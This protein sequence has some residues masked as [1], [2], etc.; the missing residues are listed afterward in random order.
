[1]AIY[2]EA[3]APPDQQAFAPLPSPALDIGGVARELWGRIQYRQ[4]VRRWDVAERWDELSPLQRGVA[5]AGMAISASM[6]VTAGVILGRTTG[7][8]AHGLEEM[9]YLPDLPAAPSG[10]LS[11]PE[12]VKTAE[13]RPSLA[14]AVM[15]AAFQKTAAE[16]EDIVLPLDPDDHP[17][18]VPLGEYD[19]KT[20]E[21][22]I[23]DQV[24]QYAHEMGYRL[25]DETPL[26]Y[27]VD[28]TLDVN[29]LS[30]R[31]ARD[32]QP[33][34][35][36]TLLSREQM[37]TILERHGAVRT[38]APDLPPPVS[39]PEPPVTPPVPPVVI[40][41]PDPDWS[42]ELPGDADVWIDD[43][44]GT[45]VAAGLVVATGAAVG[46]AVQQ[47]RRRRRAEAALAAWQREAPTVAGSG[48]VRASTV[49]R[50]P[51]PPHQTGGSATARGE[52]GNEQA[53]RQDEGARQLGADENDDQDEKRR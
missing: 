12:E 24:D 40:A 16:A 5:R 50:G 3:S 43:D 6:V 10:T 42:V 18:P 29:G 31:E 22:T 2:H 34:Y 33:G 47:R 32:L 35:E 11:T 52:A 51:V 4:I 48:G 49:Y 15:E 23:W 38:V 44:V 36:P 37:E 39:P 20:G 25:T 41:S 46:Y 45:A 19:R 21:G 30:W 26:H 9:G 14:A 53:Q 8:T 7:A 1:M 28:E 27:A 13:Q 17:Q